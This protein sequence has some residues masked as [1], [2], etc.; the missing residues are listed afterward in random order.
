MTAP[1]KP[2]IKSNTDMS[3]FDKYPKDND[4]PPIET[5]GWDDEF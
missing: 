2:K 1:V 4:T 3:N 5:S